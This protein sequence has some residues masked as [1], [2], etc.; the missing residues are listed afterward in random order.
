MQIFNLDRN[1]QSTLHIKTMDAW[2]TSSNGNT[3]LLTYKALMTEYEDYIPTVQKMIDS[4]RI[5]NS[6]FINN[7]VIH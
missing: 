1:T 2:V 3:Y 4:F 5:E 7:P 6:P